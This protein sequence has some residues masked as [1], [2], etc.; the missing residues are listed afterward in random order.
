MPTSGG[1][2]L[3]ASRRLHATFFDP[4]N[5]REVGRSDTE[6]LDD[7][8]LPQRHKLPSADVTHEAFIGPRASTSYR[9]R[10]MQTSPSPAATCLAH[11]WA[12]IWEEWPAPSCITPPPSSSSHPDR[13]VRKGVL[14]CLTALSQTS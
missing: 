3:E 2:R 7:M 14:P 11:H 4:D 8:L 5:E 6:M 13:D 12:H 9:R 1:P 10:R